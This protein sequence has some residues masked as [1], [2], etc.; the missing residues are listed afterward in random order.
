MNVGR[1]EAFDKWV[2]LNPL[3][4]A[5]FLQQLAEVRQVYVADVRSVVMK[6]AVSLDYPFVFCH[7]LGG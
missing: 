3:V 2:L 1:H 5:V 4:E 7:N 6:I